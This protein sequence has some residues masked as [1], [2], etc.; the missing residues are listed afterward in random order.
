MCDDGFINGDHGAAVTVFFELGVDSLSGG[1]EV[2]FGFAD[3]AVFVDCP[4]LY[5]A[6]VGVGEGGGAWGDEACAVKGVDPE[7]P[8]FTAH[9]FDGLS[10]VV[11]FGGFD[12]D[13]S[14]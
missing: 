11:A 4:G 5:G 2:F 6:D 7:F 1:F 8:V 12:G 9:D 10:D 13:F 14:N 3:G